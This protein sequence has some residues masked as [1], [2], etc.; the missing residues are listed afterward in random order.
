MRLNNQAKVGLATALCLLIQG[1][2]FTY[3]LGVEPGVLIAIAPIFPYIAY[4]YARASRQWYYDKPLYW[5]AAIVALT[6][7]DI[8]PFALGFMGNAGIQLT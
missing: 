3:I 8:A 6:L 7:I 5:I 1:Y 2:I 4:I